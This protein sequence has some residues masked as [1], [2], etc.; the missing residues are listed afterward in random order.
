MRAILPALFL[1]SVGVHA[2]GIDS[3]AINYAKLNPEVQAASFEIESEYQNSLDAN[4]LSGPEA[5]FEYKFGKEENRW[6]V[7]VGQSFDWPGLYSARSKANKYR[8]YSA[9]LLRSTF[10]SDKA[11]EIKLAVQTYCRARDLYETYSAT[12]SHFGMLKAAYEKNLARGECTILD[13]KRIEI[14]C[15]K[16]AVEQ[17]EV[18]SELKAA[19]ALLLSLGDQELLDAANIYTFKPSAPASF[20]YYFHAMENGSTLLAYHKS[21]SQLAMAEASVARRSALPSF[22]LSFVHDFEEG[23]HFNGFGIGIALPTWNRS[24][25]TAAAKAEYNARMNDALDCHKQLST[26]LMAEYAHATDIYPNLQASGS[27]FADNDYPALLKKALD[28][29]QITL[30]QYISEYVEYN[31]AKTTYINL[32]YDYAE[33]L[34][35]L[36]RYSISEK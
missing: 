21:Q 7:S 4:M 28:A 15:F 24:H 33:A 17:K 13:V 12:I 34:A 14:E 2:A 3:L 10:L 8:S 26:A 20:D 1:L 18:E 35:R 30:F 16:A 36:N 5:E 25:R 31:G 9:T 32:L 19:A 23:S 27:V 6:G 22:K 29:G 11:L